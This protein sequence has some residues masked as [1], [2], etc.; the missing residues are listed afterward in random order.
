MTD[1]L[2]TDT[3]LTRR[4]TARRFLL[5]AILAALMTIGGGRVGANAP[6]DGFALETAAANGGLLILL[7][8]DDGIE[9]DG[10]QAMYTALT[11]AGHQVVVVAP[12]ENQSG[13]GARVTTSGDVTVKHYHS[14]IAA[15]TAGPVDAVEFGL[16]NIFVDGGIQP[17]VVISGIN[18]GANI[19][20]G[21]IHSG[22]IGAAV[23]AINDGVPA[24]AVSQDTSG[25]FNYVQAAGFVVDLVA[26][27]DAQR[28]S[29]EPMLPLGSGLSVNVPF[30]PSQGVEFTRTGSGWIDLGFD[31]ADGLPGPGEELTYQ[32]VASTD[33]DE[34]VGDPVDTVALLEDH[35]I[36]ITPIAGNYDAASE[37][38]FGGSPVFDAVCELTTT[39]C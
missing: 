39:G 13:S 2:L 30:V 27:L 25:A 7:T 21:T 15:I 14:G 32:V 11:T 36:T 28:G 34:T 17:D 18:A 12:K 16:S 5:V 33:V 37:W 35:L 26:H 9:A 6:L 1:T 3:L 19:G 24:I 22:T 38:V 20:A 31:S 10:I 23:T 29:G 4:T 8:N